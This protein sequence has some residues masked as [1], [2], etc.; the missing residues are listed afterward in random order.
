MGTAHRLRCSGL[1]IESNPT[2][3]SQVEK[4]GQGNDPLQ[5]LVQPQEEGV[6][7]MA[8]DKMSFPLY[9]S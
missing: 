3:I 7:R 9:C 1:I 8:F 4:Q 6:G 2:S 5:E